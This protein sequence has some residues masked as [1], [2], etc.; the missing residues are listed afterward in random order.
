MTAAERLGPAGSH[1]RARALAAGK[2][3]AAL[4]A[5]HDGRMRAAAVDAQKHGVGRFDGLTV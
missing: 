2:H 5:H 1:R 4:V 3:V